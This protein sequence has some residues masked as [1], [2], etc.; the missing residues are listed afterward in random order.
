MLENV[1]EVDVL[2]APECCLTGLCPLAEGVTKVRVNMLPV[3][4]QVIVINESNSKRYAF[5]CDR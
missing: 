5:P 4:L 2:C 3:R 1:S